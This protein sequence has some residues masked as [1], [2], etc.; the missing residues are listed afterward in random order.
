MGNDRGIDCNPAST[1]LIIRNSAR[2]NT[3]NYDLV[4]GNNYGAI[5]LNPGAGFVSSNS[6]LNSEF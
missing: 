2:G 5:V 3:T 6:W 1:N 4:V